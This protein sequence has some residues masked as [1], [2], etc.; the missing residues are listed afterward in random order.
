MK[1]LFAFL[2][3]LSILALFPSCGKEPS[4]QTI[5]DIA[6]K[7]GTEDIA[8]VYIPENGKYVPFLVI[9]SGYYSDFSLLLRKELL[10]EYHRISDYNSY[11]E[12]SEMDKFLNTEY[13][14]TIDDEVSNLIC[15]V[16]IKISSRDAIGY[17]TGETVEIIRKVF[18]PSC[19]ELGIDD[20]VN[21]GKEG[22]HLS[23]FDITENRI[24]YLN[25]KAETWWLRSADTFSVSCTYYIGASGVIGSTNSYEISGVR[26]AF[27]VSGKTPII[28][29]KEVAENTEVYI[30]NT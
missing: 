12:N 27:C 9:S 10:S 19:T 16:P 30:V 2:A 18:L 17:G 25:D 20:S 8:C 5:G 29:S 14:N 6:Y 11:Y 23:Y 4:L 3:V 24:A 1:K 13:L 21:M 26:P 7:N 28:L 15:D 22:R